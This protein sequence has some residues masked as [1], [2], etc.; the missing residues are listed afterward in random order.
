MAINQTIST[1]PT[2]PTSTD[3]ATFRERADTFLSALPNL[4][5]EINNFATE[6]NT[7]ESNVNKLEQSAQNAATIAD[8]AANFKGAWDS[9]TAYTHP[10]AVIYNGV[11]YISLQ[12]STGKDPTTETTYWAVVKDQNNVI[13]KN[14]SGMP[15]ELSVANAGNTFKVADAV[16]ADEALSRQ[17]LVTS[18]PLAGSNVDLIRGLPADFTSSK[19]TNGYQKL[20]SGLIIQ[21]GNVSK[22][23]APLTVNFNISFP[24]K[25][26]SVI[27][28]SNYN[29]DTGYSVV[30]DTTSPPTT[31]QFVLV[32]SNKLSGGGYNVYWVAIGY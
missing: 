28:T 19:T 3:A 26:T 5:D 24:N 10:S 25:C 6:A 13:H 18:T 22:T 21:W 29:V 15:N 30:I 12:D 11:F 2:P 9:A 23:T 4:G 20:P 17:Q 1:I 31:T 32:D 14:G 8:V 7:L 27:A 16:N